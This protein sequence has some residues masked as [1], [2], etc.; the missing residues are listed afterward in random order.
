MVINKVENT[1]LIHVNNPKALGLLREL[2][3]MG[4]IAVIEENLPIIKPKLSDKYKGKLPS[5][6]AEKLKE[7]LKEK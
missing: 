7:S 5:E 3:A 6:V 4:L 2:E 1:M